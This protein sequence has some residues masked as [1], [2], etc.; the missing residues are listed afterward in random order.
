MKNRQDER[1]FKVLVPKYE[2]IKS[3]VEIEYEETA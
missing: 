1:L 3:V 2:I